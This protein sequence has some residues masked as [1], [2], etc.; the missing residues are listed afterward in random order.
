MRQFSYTKPKS[1]STCL[2]RLLKVAHASFPFLIIAG[3]SATGLWAGLQYNK[4]TKNPELTQPTNNTE[5]P[6]SIDVTKL[7]AQFLKNYIEAKAISPADIPEKM[8]VTGTYLNENGIH[9]FRGTFDLF[10]NGNFRIDQTDP[11]EIQITNGVITSEVT[12]IFESDI[13]AIKAFVDAIQDP[14]LKLS[15][16]KQLAKIETTQFMGTNAYEAQIESD[17]LIQKT[18]LIINAADYTLV[19]LYRNTL[20]NI[21]QKYRYSNYRTIL[22]MRFPFMISVKDLIG[23]PCRISISSLRSASETQSMAEL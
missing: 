3:I 21:G 9:A 16:G 10:G 7:K 4:T 5:Y 17:D 20:G 18:T 13:G 14:L 11:I 22:G 15:D 19:E 2:K 12:P 6:T 23:E 8:E 1:K